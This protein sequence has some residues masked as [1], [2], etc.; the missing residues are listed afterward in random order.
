MKEIIDLELTFTNM[1]SFMIMTFPFII[2][3]NVNSVYL[4]Q[5]ALRVSVIL[6][7][8]L[9]LNIPI[10]HVLTIALIVSVILN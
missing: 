7:Q 6:S 1:L 9:Q 2:I 8:A 5:R 10:P 3:F 4:S